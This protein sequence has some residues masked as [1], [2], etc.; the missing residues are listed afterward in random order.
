LKPA[1]LRRRLNVSQ[2]LT[3]HLE[4]VSVEA[5]SANAYAHISN[6]LPELIEAHFQDLIVKVEDAICS[7]TESEYSLRQD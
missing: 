2:K 3:V 1:G 6:A 4:I 7:D 5:D